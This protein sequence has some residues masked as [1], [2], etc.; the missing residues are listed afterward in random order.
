VFNIVNVVVG[1][2]AETCAQTG[3]HRARATVSPM[4]LRSESED[5]VP[6]DPDDT[7]DAPVMDAD[8]WPDGDAR[9]FAA[10]MPRAYRAL[11]DGATIATHA[12]IV[13]RRGERAAHVEI[14]K[15]LPERVVAIAVVADDRPGLLSR[16]SAALV[17][18]D[19]DVVAAQAYGRERPDGTREAVD[20]LWVRRFPTPRGAGA[21]V[22]ER[23]VARVAE[24]LDALVRGRASFDGAV[25]F[26]HAVRSSHEETRVRFERD[27]SDGGVVLTVEAVDRPGLLLLITRTLFRERVQIVGSHVTTREGRALDRFRLTELDGAPLRRA[28][29]LALQT[30]VLAAIEEARVGD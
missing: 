8:V 18:H 24:T 13:Q 11:F 28:R 4:A 22:R 20:F 21:P 6:L 15:E 30:A 19:L 10:S 14:W 12:A 25:R 27:A 3:R 16:I 1:N 2:E 17:A 5:T 9:D 29:L 7:L 23:D 26:V